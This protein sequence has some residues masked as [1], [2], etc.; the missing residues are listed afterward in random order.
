MKIRA[1]PCASDWDGDGRIDI[2]GSAAS[3]SVALFRN[4]GQNRFAAAEPLAIPPRLTAP[5]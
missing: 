1:V 5:W 3:G 4:L 2:I